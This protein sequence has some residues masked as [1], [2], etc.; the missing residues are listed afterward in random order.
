[1][2]HSQTK[3]QHRY[4]SHSEAYAKFLKRSIQ[5]TSSSNSSLSSVECHSNGL[6]N[7]LTLTYKDAVLL[8][9]KLSDSSQSYEL[10]G[11][12]SHAEEMRS[13]QENLKAVCSFCG[14]HARKTVRVVPKP[15]TSK[16]VL[17]SI[18]RQAAR[19][20]KAS[21]FDDHL[22]DIYY[23]KPSR[24][25]FQCGFCK[26]KTFK[27]GEK[28]SG[29][30]FA[31]RHSARQ[32]QQR[33]KRKQA[34]KL[35]Q[36]NIDTS[37]GESQTDSSQSA[38]TSGLGTSL[39]LSAHGATSSPLSDKKRK[40]SVSSSISLSSQKSI[41]QRTSS[42]MTSLKSNSAGRDINTSLSSSSKP[43]VMS[44]VTNKN[45]AAIIRKF[46]QHHVDTVLKADKKK[47]AKNKKKGSALESF[48]NSMK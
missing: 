8:G 18:K 16:A 31:E 47:Q 20:F 43:V 29:S 37:V 5:L 22:M 19:K 10:E 1:M 14:S 6:H 11:E 9:G 45:S 28:R 4:G 27:T 12:R 33:L 42:P 13:T 15:K 41:Q 23:N 38:G 25:Q 39:E 17:K 44:R 48:L 24:V 34:A 40:S 46:Q 35:E 21:R 3:E 36:S 26:E 7:Y 2:H 30:G 32:K